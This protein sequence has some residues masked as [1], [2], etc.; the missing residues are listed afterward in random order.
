[1][2]PLSRLLTLFLEDYGEMI[3]TF[4][5]PGQREWI[6]DQYLRVTALLHLPL[7]LGNDIEISE[8]PGG[9]SDAK[10]EHLARKIRKGAILMGGL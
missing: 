10:V 4:L 5:R 6:R 9:P 1:M 3:A 8:S 2:H 7:E